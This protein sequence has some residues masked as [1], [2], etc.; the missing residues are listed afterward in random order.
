MRQPRGFTLIEVMV[1]VVVLAI[2]V[3]TIMYT[4]GRATAAVS[5]ARGA[6]VQAYLARDIMV[7]IENKFWQKKDNEIKE[8]GD[9]GDAFPEYRYEV[10]ILENIDEKAPALVQVNVS[11]I[12]DRRGA[13]RRF[14]LSTYLLDF[15]R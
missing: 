2:G 7:E 12:W 1:A 11:V 8:S 10:E 6:T 3:S 15:T 13:E 14:T 5:A 4:I 9:F